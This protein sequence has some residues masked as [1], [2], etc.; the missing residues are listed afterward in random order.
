MQIRKATADDFSAIQELIAQFP[1]KLMQDHLPE[2]E[3][4]F[5]AID[6]DPSTGS[7]QVIG[8]CALEVYSKRLAEIRSLA[9]LPAHQGQGIASELV[10]A[11]LAE[12]KEKSV[13]EVLSVT[14]A[15]SFFEKKGFSTF[16]NE[17]YALLKIL[18]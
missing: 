14:G 4:F 7:G 1:D 3:N 9:V 16:N 15:L 8:C 6:D 12:A 17:K 10:E 18:G 11:C 13:Y 2:A 5:I